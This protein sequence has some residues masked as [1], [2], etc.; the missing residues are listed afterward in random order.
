MGRTEDIIQA[1]YEAFRRGDLS[2]ALGG[3][4]EGGR[5][6]PLPHGP[7]YHGRDEVRKFLSEDIR[8]LAEFDFRVYTILEQGDF[9]LI[10]GRYSIREHEQVVEKGVFWISHIEEGTMRSFEAYENVGEAFAEFKRRL[11]GG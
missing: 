3:W 7:A 2:G 11:G 9:A 8:E 1:N 10:F 4:K 5:F 6:R